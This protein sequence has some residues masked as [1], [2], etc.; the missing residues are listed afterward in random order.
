[1][2][3]AVM[4]LPLIG[5]LHLRRALLQAAALAAAGGVIGLSLRGA[6]AGWDGAWAAEGGLA[7]LVG[8]EPAGWLYLE[9]QPGGAARVRGVGAVPASPA[10]ALAVRAGEAVAV[11]GRP[12]SWLR[13]TAVSPGIS[14][15]AP[16]AWTLP[17]DGRLALPVVELGGSGP[18]RAILR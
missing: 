1:M 13:I 11:Q 17:A 5:V 16:G 4:A 6:P 9:A 12:G 14:A 10:L 8:G 7:A 2:L 3:P 18:G 15:P